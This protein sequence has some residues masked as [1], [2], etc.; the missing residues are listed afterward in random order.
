MKKNLNASSIVGFFVSATLTIHLA[1]PLAHG[2]TTGCTDQSLTL[3]EE[4]LTDTIRYVNASQF[5]RS[6]D[7]TNSNKWIAVGARDWTSGFFPGWIWYMYEKTLSDSWLIRAK[8]QTESLQNED[9]NASDHDIGFKILGSYGNGY[10]ITRDPYYMSVIQT[11]A[12]SLSTLYR[13]EAG[14]IE[15]WP[16]FDDKVTVI[17]DNMMNLELLFF[18]A[19]NGGD[20]SW[21]NMAVS[22]AL[23]TMQNHVR[24]DG[25]TYHV[26]DYNSDGTVHRKFTVQGAGTETTWSRG[27][28][29]G[30]YGFTMTYRY[31]KDPRFLLTAQRLADY[32]IDN[33][34]PDYVPYWDFSKCCSDPRDSSAAAIAAAGLLELS[35]LVANRGDKERYYNAA[36]NIQTSLSSSAY[37]GDRLDTNGILLHGSAEVPI[38]SEVDVSLI[39]GDYYF[40]QGCYRGK[41]PPPAPTNLTAAAAS[42]SQINL[43]WDAETAGVRYSVKRGTTPGGLHKTIAPPPVL[44]TNTYVD[45]SVVAGTTYYYVVSATNVAG[46]SPDSTTAS[47]TTPNSA[48]TIWSVSPT[49]VAAGAGFTLN[50]SGANF[51]ATSVINFAGRPEPTT[52]V[53]STRLIAAIPASDVPSGG[54]PAV[55]VSN[56]APGGGESVAVNFT[57]D[58]FA[59]SGPADPL[60]V[61]PGKST[62]ITIAVAPSNTNGFANAVT[63]S[64]LGLPP[65]TTATFNPPTVTPAGNSVTTTLKISAA[66]TSETSRLSGWSGSAPRPVSF[67]LWLAAALSGVLSLT[68]I[69]QGLRTRRYVAYLPLTLLFVSLGGLS[70]CASEGGMSPSPARAFHLIVTAT[71]GTDTKTAAITLTLLR[72]AK[73]HSDRDLVDS[74]GLTRFGI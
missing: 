66:T 18:A 46:K 59:V 40:I 14:V 61:A 70:G 37:L 41:T 68:L 51:V 47:V 65:A 74:V 11:A 22:H 3:A 71:S 38:W 36:L 29:W 27:Q 34:P 4:H 1:A 2:Q 44:T 9:T 31:T 63:F 15:S 33:L 19:Q 42:D 8:A 26:V 16:N 30:L 17:I 64:V 49:N 73:G 6:T 23:K 62:A 69:R 72:G 52:F 58:D 35:T 24:A 12:K 50:V 10:R 55:T 53:S 7:P 45:T 32:F 13:P 21:R 54:T 20:P 57:I 39:Y 28:A 5:A 60:T 48:P 56:P 25:S 43:T 67:T